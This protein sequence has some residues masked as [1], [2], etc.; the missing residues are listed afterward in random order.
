[1]KWPVE[2]QGDFQQFYGLNFNRA[3][4][5]F[6]YEYAADL[7]A[8]LPNDSRIA[9]AAN[10]AN[11]WTPAEYMLANIEY[12]SAWLAWSRSKDAKS[13]NNK[14][15]RRL[16][17]IEISQTRTKLDDTDLREIDA[18]LGYA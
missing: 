11:E 17:P 9:K 5:D 2:L 8:T 6:S 7:A 1:M 13:G 16:T 15:K 14:P 18:I 10:P 4:I 12:A 3:G